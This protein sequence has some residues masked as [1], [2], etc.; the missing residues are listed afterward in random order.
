MDPVLKQFTDGADLVTV[1]V[2]YRLSPEHPYPEPLEDAIDAMEWLID[3]AEK[4]FG[5]PLSFIGG[6]VR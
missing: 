5:G 3:N 6:D 4:T 1:S 2:G